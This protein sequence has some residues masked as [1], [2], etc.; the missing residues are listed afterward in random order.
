MSKAIFKIDYTAIRPMDIFFTSAVGIFPALIRFGETGKLRE[1]ADHDLPN[2]CG[3]FTDW[4]LQFLCTEV[5]A[6]G[7]ENNSPDLY[8]TNRNH[9]VSIYRWSGYDDMDR[10]ETAQRYLALWTRRAQGKGYDLWGAVRSA[11]RKIPILGKLFKNDPSKPFC[12]ESVYD[13]LRKE[14]AALP[15]S[16]VNNP[17][18]PLML[19]DY[20]GKSTA[21]FQVP[22][23]LWR[24]PI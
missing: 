16:W 1:M 2:H 13:H 8:C 15:L 23:A 3:F 14:G 4:H 21:F 10:R 9:I 19:Q 11:G 12:S 20:M 22:K 5:K 6:K 24:N 18:N 7:P 17:P